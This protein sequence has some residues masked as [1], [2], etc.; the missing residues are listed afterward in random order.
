MMVMSLFPLL[1]FLILFIPFSLLYDYGSYFLTYLNG[2][3]KSFLLIIELVFDYIAISIFFLRL[4]VQNVRLA[5]MLFTF[6]ELHELI[7]NTSYDKNLL[8]AN[9]SSQ[10]DLN[11]N[12]ADTSVSFDSNFLLI[13][14]PL[15]ILN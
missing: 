9:D 2:V 13:T 14:L 1:Y 5:F 3:G 15:K 11:N 8:I 10:N 6:I 4:T 12:G 7:L